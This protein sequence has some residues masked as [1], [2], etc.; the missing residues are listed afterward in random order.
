MQL[1]LMNLLSGMQ[2]TLAANIAEAD[3]QE[4]LDDLIWSLSL[5]LSL[6]LFKYMFFDSL[7]TAFIQREPPGAPHFMSPANPP[8]SHVYSFSVSSTNGVS[9]AS[10]LEARK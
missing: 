1:Y 10:L 5:T 8:Y 7:V 4:G 6:T 3:N 2:R 9:I